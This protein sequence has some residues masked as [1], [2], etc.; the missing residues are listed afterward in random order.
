MSDD[1]VAQIIVN[2]SLSSIEQVR[3]LLGGLD[4]DKLVTIV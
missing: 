3:Q 4:I 2:E 1:M